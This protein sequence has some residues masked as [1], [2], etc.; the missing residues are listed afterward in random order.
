M[1]VAVTVL[2]MVVMIQVGDAHVLKPQ[3]PVCWPSWG[4]IMLS[5]KP[6]G[7]EK[8]L[9]RFNDAETECQCWL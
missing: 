9:C 6:S 8:M 1:L 2:V 7:G 4:A 3:G 5:Q